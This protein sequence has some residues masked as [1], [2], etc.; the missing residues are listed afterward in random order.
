MDRSPEGEVALTAG[1]QSVR[2]RGNWKMLP[3]NSV[4]NYHGPFVHNV[5]F[6]LSDK[7][8][9][10]VRPPIGKRLP[11]QPDETVSLAGGHMAEFLPP[12]GLQPSKE[13]SEARKAYLAAMIK[14]HGEKRARELTETPPAFF[15]VFPNLLF[16]QT[17]FRRLQPVSV[18]ETFVYYQPALLK[19]VP[20]EINEDILR[21]HEASFGPAGLV[22]PDDIQILERNQAGLRAEGNEW[23][24]IGRGVHRESRY[25]DG[26][27]SG[28]FLDENHLR[29]F[30]SHYARLMSAP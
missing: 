11:D 27:T 5:A 14:V 23:L 13:A 30:W 2:Y 19:G 25:E 26:G 1:T 29:G 9:G 22:T 3:E 7:R 12:S 17:H 24:F 8:A 6:G 28:H 21:F 20:A 10:R 18:D 16:I 4:E 15:F